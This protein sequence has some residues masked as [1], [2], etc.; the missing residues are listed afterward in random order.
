M[1]R[2]AIL[3]VSIWDTILISLLAKLDG[4]PK[5]ARRRPLNVK[6]N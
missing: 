4:S 6:L 3:N 2:D 5:A 1:A